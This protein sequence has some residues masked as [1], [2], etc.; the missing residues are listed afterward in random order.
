MLLRT[1]VG[2]TAHV[3]QHRGNINSFATSQFGRR[4]CTV[5]ALIVVS[6]RLLALTQI[7][8]LPRVKGLGNI[9]QRGE[10][11]RDCVHNIFSSLSSIGIRSW[12][13]VWDD[14]VYQSE[15]TVLL[16]FLL[17]GLLRLI[18]RCYSLNHCG[19]LETINKFT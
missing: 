5:V 7:G 2:G 4:D 14:E 8:D 15:Y 1:V 18:L 16:L 12:G 9:F 19:S 6:E 17:Q 3:S 10:Q 13:A 11:C